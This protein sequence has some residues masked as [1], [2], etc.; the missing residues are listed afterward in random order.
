MFDNK[1]PGSLPV[2]AGATSG[3]PAL[4]GRLPAFML[5]SQHINFFA[6]SDNYENYT[7]CYPG[8]SCVRITT[9]E[10]VVNILWG[11]LYVLRMDKRRGKERVEDG[12]GV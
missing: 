1:Q 7:A 6:I 3:A 8:P 4:T 11:Y 5:N 2:S 12:K 9:R 10:Y